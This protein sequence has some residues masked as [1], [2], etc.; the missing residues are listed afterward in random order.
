[1][2]V[3]HF[4]GWQAGDE[5][6]AQHVQTAAVDDGV[7]NGIMRVHVIHACHAIGI[8][9]IERAPSF[10]ER[11]TWKEAFVTSRC[12]AGSAITTMCPYF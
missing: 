9:C 8:P 2:L 4:A 11:G 3:N 12:E 5:G 6:G 10:Q 7:L 1:M